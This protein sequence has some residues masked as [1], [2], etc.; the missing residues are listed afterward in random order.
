MNNSAT[1]V[2]VWRKRKLFWSCTIQAIFE[3]RAVS[4]FSCSADPLFL[5]SSLLAPSRASH[6]FTHYLMI[7][8]QISSL[9]CSSVRTT[10]NRAN[11]GREWRFIRRVPLHRRGCVMIF[12]S[13]LYVCTSANLNAFLQASGDDG[14]SFAASLDGI[15]CNRH[16]TTSTFILKHG[17]LFHYVSS[18]MVNDKYSSFWFLH[19]WI[20]MKRKSQV[21]LASF[22]MACLVCRE[23]RRSK[24]F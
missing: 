17:H 8:I 13:V 1:V 19:F 9:S 11:R 15:T 5:S 3:R 18:W 7:K 23:V 20:F 14:C 24:T 10:A 12:L 22:H 4:A 2:E 16:F 6:R 21:L